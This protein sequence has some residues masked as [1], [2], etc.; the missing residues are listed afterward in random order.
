M[1]PSPIGPLAGY[2]PVDPT[3]ELEMSIE[4]QGV[5]FR[6]MKKLLSKGAYCVTIQDVADAADVPYD[7]AFT[8]V[9]LLTKRGLVRRTVGGYMLTGK[10]E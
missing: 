9:L 2:K 1:R 3:D 8:A 6:E 10:E 5:F 4:D 7:V